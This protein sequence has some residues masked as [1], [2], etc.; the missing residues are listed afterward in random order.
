KLLSK[1]RCEG[2]RF[3]NGIQEVGGSSPLGSTTKNT[4]GPAKA[5]PFVGHQLGINYSSTI[6]FC[7]QTSTQKGV[8][9][10]FPVD[11]F[12]PPRISSYSVRPN[13]GAGGREFKS[14]RPDHF[15]GV[16]VLRWLSP[17]GYNQVCNA[18]VAQW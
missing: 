14:H 4:K 16:P 7:R 6:V 2:L 18:G 1:R 13:L 12:G 8:E 5:G 15:V 10:A 9:N 11:I 3:L 17:F